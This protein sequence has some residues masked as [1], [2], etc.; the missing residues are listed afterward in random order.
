MQLAN[1]IKR[2]PGEGGL[3]K[4][5]VMQMSHSVCDLQESV[6]IEEWRHAL[7][8]ANEH[9][10]SFNANTADDKHFDVAHRKMMEFCEFEIK[11]IDLDANTTGTILAMMK[12]PVLTR[13]W[14]VGVGADYLFACHLQ[15]LGVCQMLIK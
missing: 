7:T 3:G 14:T 1:A 10:L 2:A 9:C 11:P 15:M 6:D 4:R 12:A 8:R 5:N 13:W